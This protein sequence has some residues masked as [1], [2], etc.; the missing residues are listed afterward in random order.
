MRLPLPLRHLLPVLALALLVAGT[1]ARAEDEPITLATIKEEVTRPQIQV[2]IENDVLAGSDRYYTNGFK[3]GGGGEIPLLGALLKPIPEAILDVMGR[4]GPDG[5][6]PR[7]HLGFFIGQNIY[8]PKDIGITGS[9]PFDR[10]WAAWLYLGSVVQRVRGNRLDTVE[11]DIGMVGPAAL[12]KPVQSA[13]HKLVGAA[14]PKGWSNQIPNEPAIMAAY[15]QKRRF[16]TSTIQIVPHAGITLG[17]V[18]RLARVGGIVRIGSRMTGF[19]PDSIE[20]GGAMLQTTRAQ[21]SQTKNACCEW[22]LFAG[23]DYRL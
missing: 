1:S 7:N 16:G 14:Q 4:E 5:E 11:L 17:T 3:L 19:G 2:F 6:T 20:P 18:M 21:E 12:G 8:T 10:P 22:Y 9:Q 15:L 13:W 23:G